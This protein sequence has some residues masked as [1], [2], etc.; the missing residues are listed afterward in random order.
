M[1]CTRSGSKCLVPWP[2]GGHIGS[3]G[4]LSAKVEVLVAGLWSGW[5]PRPNCV[6]PD[7]STACLI[8][9]LTSQGLSPGKASD[10]LA[11]GLAGALSGLL[12]SPY[13]SAAQE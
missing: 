1:P 4:Q 13:P 12:S 5:T 3:R 11:A 6:C 9:A 8:S 7:P 2:A 10:S